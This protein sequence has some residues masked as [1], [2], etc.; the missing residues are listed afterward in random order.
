M[1]AL[2][3]ISTASALS[4]SNTERPTENSTSSALE[5]MWITALSSRRVTVS[6]E[7]TLYSRL[8]SDCVP[9]FT[10]TR[11]MNVREAPTSSFSSL[12]V[13]SPSSSRTYTA[14]TGTLPELVT[15]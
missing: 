11:L 13:K 14:V 2:V 10:V 9:V 3:R 6:P 1:P 5:D 4:G 15:R 12:P 8:A 7:G